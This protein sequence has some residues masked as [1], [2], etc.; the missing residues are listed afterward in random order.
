M[1]Y[2]QTA[3]LATVSATFGTTAAVCLLALQCGNGYFT[4]SYFHEPGETF[5]AAFLGL[6]L[7]QSI[8]L[9]AV[10]IPAARG[11]GAA[12]SFRAHSTT[13]FS[14]SS[15]SSSATCNSTETVALTSSSAH[16][17]SPA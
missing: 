8:T 15:S 10:V 13:S 2:R 12:A 16:D 1:T 14:S 17:M 11:L 6:L 4:A 9:V 7:C 3:T 5:L